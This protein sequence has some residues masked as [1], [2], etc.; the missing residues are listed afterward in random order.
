MGGPS[1]STAHVP[2]PATLPA[3]RPT[4]GIFNSHYVGQPFNLAASPIPV[5]GAQALGSL[6]GLLAAA[7]SE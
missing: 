7:L 4:R 3:L 2:T 6:L 1:G 5:F